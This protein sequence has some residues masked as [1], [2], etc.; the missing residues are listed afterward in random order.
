MTFM[1]MTTFYISIVRYF[2]KVTEKCNLLPTHYTSFTQTGLTRQSCSLGDAHP[3]SVFCRTH[4]HA[5]IH[6]HIR[7]H[8]HTHT[9][10]LTNAS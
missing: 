8:A 5:D 4:M 3:T 7:A 2:N 6:T 10:T 9:H 1:S